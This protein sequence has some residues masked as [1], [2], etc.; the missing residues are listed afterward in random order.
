MLPVG[1]AAV[2][3]V[4]ELLGDVVDV[5]DEALVVGLVDDVAPVL[6][7]LVVFVAVLGVVLEVVLVPLA[8]GSHG[9][10]LGVVL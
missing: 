9:T 10:V 5:L 8:A 3:V 7:A 6:A 4:L 2:V 1:V